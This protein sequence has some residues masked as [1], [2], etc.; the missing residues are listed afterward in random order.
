MPMK[1]YLVPYFNQ[2]VNQY[3]FSV[4]KVSH[5]PCKDS[6]CLGEKEPTDADCIRAITSKL[7]AGLIIEKHN[8]WF[9][10]I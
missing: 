8:G 10:V 5:D 2:R 9:R 4:W 6:I 7:G 3:N 1:Y